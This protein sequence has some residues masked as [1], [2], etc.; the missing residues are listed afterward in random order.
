MLIPSPCYLPLPPAPPPPRTIHWEMYVD[1]I[2]EY[3]DGAYPCGRCC[4][5][6]TPPLLG[7]G[8][9]SP[10]ERRDSA[11]F[12][13]AELC[14]L[15][16]QRRAWRSVKAVLSWAV[17]TKPFAS[18]HIVIFFFFFLI[19]NKFGFC[20][21]NHEF[22]PHRTHQRPVKLIAFPSVYKAI[23][24]YKEL[25]FLSHAWLFLFFFFLLKDVHSTYQT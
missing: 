11:G 21:A 1:Q 23:L 13:G 16:A 2:D 25:I 19:K 6:C 14:C 7:W 9:E 24:Y 8:L 17:S 15:A 12:S 4:V 18:Y 5:H 22:I 20:F 3:S 10:S